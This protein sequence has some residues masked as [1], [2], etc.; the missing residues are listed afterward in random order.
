MSERMNHDF[1]GLAGRVCVVTGAGGGIGRAIA[2]TLAAE[3]AKVAI[4]DW[5]AAAADETAALVTDAGG[6]AIAVPCDV[7][8]EDSV[9][10]AATRVGAEI[11]QAYLLVNCVGVMRRGPLESLSLADWNTG[12]SVNLSGYFLCSQIF[13]RAMRAG[14]SGVLIHVSSIQGSYPSVSAGAYSTAKAGLNMLSRQLAVEWGPHGIRSNVVQPA[15]VL[16]PMSAAM[17]ARPGFTE[18]RSAL[19]P[20]G[21]IGTPEDTAQAVLFLASDRASYVNGAELL[22]DGGLS[23]NLMSLVPR[24]VS[25]KREE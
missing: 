22:V 24:A 1:F 4:L 18:M 14:G 21:R 16:T 12:L 25:N 20:T 11:G 23:A 10:A 15:W 17:Y 2:Q 6:T 19:V 7:S 13:G 3:G 8:S 5:D 9:E